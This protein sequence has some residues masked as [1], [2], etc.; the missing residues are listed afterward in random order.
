MIKVKGPFLGFGKWRIKELLCDVCQSQ[1]DAKSEYVGNI[2]FSEDYGL[3]YLRTHCHVEC[4]SRMSLEQLLANHDCDFRDGFTLPEWK[5]R[6]MTSESADGEYRV[7]F[8]FVQDTTGLLRKIVRCDDCGSIAV[9]TLPPE[10]SD[11]ALKVDYYHIGSSEVHSAPNVCATSLHR[12]PTGLVIAKRTD[13]LHAFVRLFRSGDPH[14]N[15]AAVRAKSKAKIATMNKY[16]REL[17]AFFGGEADDIYSADFD[18]AIGYTWYWCKWCGDVERVI[19]LPDHKP[20]I[21]GLNDCSKSGPY[22]GVTQSRVAGAPVCQ[23]ED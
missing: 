10:V 3:I 6:D 15:L 1:I 11:P 20:P 9:V 4:A 5:K 18:E 22:G 21:R 16:D 19:H 14:V 13:C 7:L 12:G 23:V 8:D 2:E 17:L